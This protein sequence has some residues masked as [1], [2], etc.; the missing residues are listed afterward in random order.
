MLLLTVELSDH[1]RQEKTRN[2]LAPL[3]GIIMFGRISGDMA[4]LDRLGAIAMRLE[5]ADCP[6]S[7]RSVDAPSDSC[8]FPLSAL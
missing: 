1:L 6:P 7:G 4:I 3:P 2:L 8:I 5:A